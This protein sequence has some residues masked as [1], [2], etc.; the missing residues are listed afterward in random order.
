MDITLYSDEKI[1]RGLRILTEDRE[2]FQK[3]LKEHHELL[4]SV[5]KGRRKWEAEEVSAKITEINVDIK[6]FEDEL[7]R[8]GIS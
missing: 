5:E 6:E 4:A 3:S 2:A 7:K 1:R 8:R